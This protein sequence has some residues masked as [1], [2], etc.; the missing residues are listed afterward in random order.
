MILAGV[1]FYAF[2]VIF[3]WSLMVAAKRGDD[4]RAKQIF[5]QSK[6]H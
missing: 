2:S 3:G 1:I 4:E 6:M 5:R